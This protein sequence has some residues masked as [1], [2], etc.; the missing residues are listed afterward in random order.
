MHRLL[1]LALGLLVLAAAAP[2]GAWPVGHRTVTYLDPARG[3]RA[4]PTDVYYPANIAGENAPVAGTGTGFPVVSFGHGYLIGSDLYSFVW[5][6]LVP[7]GY[8]VALPATESGTTPDQAALGEDLAFLV[9][10]LKAESANPASFLYHAV[11][12][13]GA[14]AGHSMGGAVSF[15]GAAGNAGVDA[16]VTF[17][18]STSTPSAV[19]AA[20]QVTVPTLFIAGENDCLA[21]PSVQDLL[22]MESASACKAFVEIADASHCQFNDYSASCDQ[23][24]SC[25]AGIPAATQHALTVALM[26]PWL[27]AV[28]KDSYGAW[29]NFTA[30]AAGSYLSDLDCPVAPAVP[31]CVN[32]RDDDGDGHIDAADGGCSGPGDDSESPTGCGLGAELAAL[33]PAL[34]WLA[35]RRSRVP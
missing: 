11:A 10:K 30:T 15:L 34:G 2:A 14:V 4:I 18:A 20:G 16:V 9:N 12:P 24:E 6:A 32:G 17:A 22:Y 25:S 31:D 5:N 3:N 33:L 35:R 23:A 27:D 26:K 19:P 1:P 29:L 21:P 8:I 13:A 7:Y 28:L